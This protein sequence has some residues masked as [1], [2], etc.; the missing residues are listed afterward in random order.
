MCRICYTI[1]C[2][3]FSVS[4]WN[5]VRLYL[6]LQSCKFIISCVPVKYQY[7]CTCRLLVRMQWFCG[8]NSF[9]INILCFY[10]LKLLRNKWTD[11]LYSYKFQIMCSIFQIWWSFINL[12]IFNL[13][14]ELMHVLLVWLFLYQENNFLKDIIF[15]RNENS[16]SIAPL[17]V[18]LGTFS[19]PPKVAYLNTT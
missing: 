11:C 1:I 14:L 16:L 2:F 8:I 4:I 5:Y 6:L 17:S 12:F 19:I 13:F 7:I 9:Y 15:S 10:M 3:S 18:H